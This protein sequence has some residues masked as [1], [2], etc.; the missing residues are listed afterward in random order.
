MSRRYAP[1]VEAWQVRRMTVR[2]TDQRRGPAGNRTPDEITPGGLL[3]SNAALLLL[4]V[5]AIWLFWV[6]ADAVVNL[7][8]LSGPPVVVAGSFHS[9]AIAD[10][11][12]KLQGAVGRQRPAAGSTPGASAGAAQPAGR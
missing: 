7:G 10:Y 11:A 1:G 6:T 9:D 12:T 2:R 8:N 4:C 3:H 5:A